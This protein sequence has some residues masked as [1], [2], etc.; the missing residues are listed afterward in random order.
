ML[1]KELIISMFVSLLL[2]G[3]SGTAFATDAISS[4]GVSHIHTSQAAME[5]VDTHD[6]SMLEQS[7]VGTEA[8]NWEYRFDTPKTPADVAAI[9]HKYDQRKLDLV[10]TEAG[11]G[12][13]LLCSTC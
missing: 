2:V 10:G 1:R 6:Y 5:A 4:E 13:G 8:G 7:K 12:S 3:L 11:E 9:N